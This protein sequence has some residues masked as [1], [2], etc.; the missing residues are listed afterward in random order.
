VQNLSPTATE[1]S[2]SFLMIALGPS[3]LPARDGPPLPGHPRRESV[4]T[5]SDAWGNP[6]ERVLDSL[7][8]QRWCLIQRGEQQRLLEP[9]VAA[10][11][12]QPPGSDQFPSDLDGPR[13][14]E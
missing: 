4:G 14:V 3:P 8:E 13:P 5:R 2:E 10:E 7:A 12:H 6:A 9:V 1:K 11:D